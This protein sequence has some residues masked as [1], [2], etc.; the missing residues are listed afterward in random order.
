MAMVYNLNDKISREKPIIVIGDREIKV[1][2]GAKAYAR[3]EAFRENTVNKYKEQMLQYRKEN[4][5]STKE[6]AEEFMKSKVT[7]A[8]NLEIFKIFI[9]EEDTEYIIDLDLDGE[10]L[11][12]VINAILAASKKMTLEDYLKAVEEQKD[13]K[14]VK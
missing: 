10:D 6:D 1:N 4:P 9:S 14:K 12:T 8:D 13:K 3:F 11:N 2:S 7:F 5:N